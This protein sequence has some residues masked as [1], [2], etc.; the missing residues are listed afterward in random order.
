MIEEEMLR[1]FRQVERMDETVWHNNEAVG[2]SVSP[3]RGCLLTP[4]QKQAAAPH[5]ATAIIYNSRALFHI[6]HL[7]YFG[8]NKINPFTNQT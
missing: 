5:Q 2:H 1:L 6:V 3:A 4:Q 7:L 8:N